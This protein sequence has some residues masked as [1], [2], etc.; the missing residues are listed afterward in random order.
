LS[1]RQ[2]AYLILAAATGAVLL[3]LPVGA[4]GREVADTCQSPAYYGQSDDMESFFRL[5]PY[6]KGRNAEHIYHGNSTVEVEVHDLSTQHNFRIRDIS[7]KGS[8]V[9]LVTSTDPAYTGVQ[10]W[11]VPL[12]VRSGVESGDY[13]WRSDQDP[14]LRYGVFVNHPVG[15]PPPPPPPPPGAPPPPP[16][17]GPPPPPPPG[18][19]PPP[20]P[21]PQIPDFIFTSGPGQQIGVYYAD[22]RRMTRIPPGT[23]TIQV[24]DL[25]TTHDFHLTG[26]GG[27]DRKTDVGEIEH[28]IWTLTFRA[29]TYTFRCDVHASMRGTF[30]VAVGA[31]APP[32]C[33][34]PR[35]VGKRLALA[36][37]T[38]RARH[39]RVGRVRYRRAQR[40]RGRILSQS[41][42]AGRRLANGARV[43]LV[44]SRGPG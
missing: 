1:G 12:E 20:P 19:T 21:P 22:G 24:H 23:Y 33:N 40:T 34:V 36:R 41:P 29:G 17:A 32:R 30:V 43:N 38:I 44:V 3:A 28:P 42:R 27:I 11:L 13:L 31:P 15:G 10:C 4:S 37:R 39:C 26:P 35:V 5:P 9:D 14:K 16:P 6:P 7:W 18:P 8:H 25:A 2:I